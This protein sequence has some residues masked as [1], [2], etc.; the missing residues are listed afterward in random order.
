MNSGHDLGGMQGFGPVVSEPE[1]VVFHADWEPKVLALV[2]AM[3]AAGK[4]NLDKSRHARESLPPPDYLTFS[5]YQIWLAALE[6]LMVREKLVT[7][8]ELDAGK[9]IEPPI[10][11]KGVLKPE[12]VDTILRSG[13]PCDRDIDAAAKFNKG[14]KIRVKNFHP[15]SHTRAPRYLRGH[16]GVVEEVHGGFVFPD[17]N[18]SD[19]GECPQRVYTLRFSARELWGEQ[20]RASDSVMADLWE[21]YLEHA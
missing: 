3:A 19:Q 10:P 20:A 15:E 16:V 17:T 21:S 8:E 5:Y 14:D 13:G 2:L 1:T 12:M 9:M 18:A 4:W 11:V 7:R 6:N